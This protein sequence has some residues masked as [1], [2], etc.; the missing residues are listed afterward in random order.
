MSPRL[1]IRNLTRS[2]GGRVAVSDVSLTVSAGEV[3]C[4]LGPSGC[5]KSTTLRMIAGVETPDSGEILLD[6]THVCHPEG[7]LPPEA[8]EVGLMFQ[9]FALFPHLTVAANVGFGLKRK[10]PSRV[11]ALLSRVGLSHLAGSYPH[12][13]SGGEQQRVAL[14]RA[15]GPSPKV[16][17][18]DEPFSGLDERLRD[19]IRDTTLSVIKDEGTAVVLVT[20]E[21]DEAMRMGDRIA[22]MRG[23]RVV[24]EGTPYTIYNAPADKQA[25]GIFS[26]INVVP[27]EVHGALAKTPFGEFLAPGLQDG[28]QIDI[29]IRP[30]HL[31]IDF[32]RAGTGPAPTPTMGQAAHAKVRRARFLGQHSLVDFELDHEGR[33]LVLT[34]SVPSVFLPKPGTPFWLLAPRKYCHVFGR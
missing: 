6:G 9:E 7:R 23:G 3:L 18:M 30:Q 17:L 21:P 26:D 33:G 29:V 8:R 10:D 27:A 25:A 13:L 15:L 11:D 4:L 12:E 1:E 20:H 19:E 16:M 32:D 24:Q 28:D 22:L 14:A 31:R 2:F 5:G 34:A